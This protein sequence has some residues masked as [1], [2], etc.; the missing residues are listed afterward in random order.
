MRHSLTGE[1][2]PNSLDYSHRMIERTDR[3]RDALK[4]VPLSAF[5]VGELGALLRVFGLQPRIGWN[6]SPYVGDIKLLEEK[7]AIF[8]AAQQ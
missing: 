1:M 8:Q 7:I 6:T 2:D 5:T 3:L 4:D